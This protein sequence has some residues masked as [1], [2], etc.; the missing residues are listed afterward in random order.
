MAYSDQNNLDR[1]IALLTRLVAIESGHINGRVALGVALFRNKQ[2]AEGLR[3]LEIALRQD[4]RNLWAHRN[5]AAGLAR[6]GRYSDA[7]EHFRLATEI[8]P[9]DQASWYGYG[10]TLEHLEKSEDADRAYRKIIQLNEFGDFAELA[11]KALSELAQ[12]TFRSKTPNLERMDAVM[13]CLSALKL[14][15]GMTPDQVQKIGFEIAMLGTHGIEVNDPSVKYT[16]HSLPG[17]F[18]GLHLL[19]LQYVAFKQILPAQ[20]IGFDLAAEYRKALTM[21]ESKAN[22]A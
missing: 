15:A 6:L 13:Y 19:S 7:E 16:I 14:F 12:K 18:S 8:D 9:D 1:A 10:Q 3:E 21:F 11:E 4:P 20:D 5:L 2:D 17:E 22:H